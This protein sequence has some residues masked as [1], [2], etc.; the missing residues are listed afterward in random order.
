MEEYSDFSKNSQSNE[1]LDEQIWTSINLDTNS[2]NSI[3]TSDL[4]QLLPVYGAQVVN[5]NTRYTYKTNEV[6]ELETDEDGNFILVQ[7]TP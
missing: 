5:T 3:G 1:G 4:L 6:G 2:D 7:F